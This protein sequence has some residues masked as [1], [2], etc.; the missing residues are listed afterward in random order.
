MRMAGQ[1]IVI[2]A[3]LAAVMWGTYGLSVHHF[4]FVR[5]SLVWV[6]GT[7]VALCVGG[8]AFNRAER[9]RV[10]EQQFVD[11]TIDAME[12]DWYAPPPMWN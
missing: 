3:P 8:A 1:G 9:R 7:A 10:I 11:D 12:A 2:A 6:A 4:G 5:G